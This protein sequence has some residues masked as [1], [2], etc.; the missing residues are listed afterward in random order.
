[1]LSP[2]PLHQSPTNLAS[3][4]ESRVSVCAFMLRPACDFEVDGTDKI[5]TMVEIHLNLFLETLQDC[6]RVLDSLQEDMRR[7]REIPQSSRF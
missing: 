3:T 1:M 4:K 2:Q 5:L 7:D 6:P